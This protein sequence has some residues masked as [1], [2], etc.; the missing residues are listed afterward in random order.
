[1]ILSQIHATGKVV[2]ANEGG[3]SAPLSN[4]TVSTER[5]AFAVVAGIKHFQLYL[6]DR[7]FTA[8]TEH[9]ALRWLINV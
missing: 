4:I 5:E 9:N 8:H 1:M 2:I 3:N 7:A 6:Y